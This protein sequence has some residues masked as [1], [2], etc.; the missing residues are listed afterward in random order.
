[1]FREMIHSIAACV[2]TF[3]LCVVI[4]PTIVWG[5][6]HLGFHSKATGSLVYGNKG[7][8]IGSELVAQAFTTD[9]YFHPRPSAVDYKADAAGGSNLAPTNPALREKVV[10]RLKSLNATTSRPAPVELVTASGGGLDPDISPEAAL[11]QAARV[12]EARKIPL[13]TVKELIE[14]AT[15]REGLPFGNPARVN[16]L[17]LNLQL[18]AQNANR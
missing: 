4:Y 7:E 16:V 17:K 13:G 5:I 15:N 2:V 9:Q 12:A 1:M 3:A 10:E 18:D 8:V 14:R 6:A 11:Y